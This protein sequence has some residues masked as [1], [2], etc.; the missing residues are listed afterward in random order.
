MTESSQINI[1]VSPKLLHLLDQFCND[2]TDS[3][4]VQGIVI[5]RVGGIRIL[6][7]EALTARGYDPSNVPEFKGEPHTLQEEN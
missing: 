6:V 1:R 5:N 2:L 3:I 7:L 4:S